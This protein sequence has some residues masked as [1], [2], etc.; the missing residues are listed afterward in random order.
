MSRDVQEGQR[1]KARPAMDRTNRD[2]SFPPALSL[3]RRRLSS[4][5]K[6]QIS[7]SPRLGP[8]LPRSFYVPSAD[9]VAPQLLGHWLVRTTSDGI[10]A[11]L[12]VET[13]AYLNDDP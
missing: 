4:L 2:A 9:Q 10:V 1:M 6:G 12:I 11:G 13:E 8:P 3:R 5:L 7:T